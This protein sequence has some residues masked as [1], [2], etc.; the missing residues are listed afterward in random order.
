LILLGST[1]FGTA[2]GGGSSDYGTVFDILTNGTGFTTLASFSG[3]ND[4]A[5]PSAGLIYTLSGNALYGTAVY[6][7]TA[8]NG[9]V[10]TLPL[11]LAASTTAVSSSSNP[12]VY[13]QSGVT[14]TATVTSLMGTPT[15]TVQFLTNGQPFDSETLSGGTATSV[16]LPLTLSADNYTVTATYSGD[17]DFTTSSGSLSGGQ[18]VNQA[19]TLTVVGS[20]DAGTSVYGETGATFTATV[21]SATSGTPTGTVQFY[22]NTVAFG[23]AV[24][25]SGGTASSGALP[26]SLPGGNYGVT[27]I[28]SGDPN[29]ITSSGS[30]SGGQTV[31]KAASSMTLADSPDSNTSVYGQ[32][33]VTF[34]ATVSD[35]SSGSSGTPTGSVQFFTNSVAFGNPVALTGGPASIAISGSLSITLMP[36]NYTVTASYSGDQD[37]STCSGTLSGGQ[38]VS[39]ATSLTSVTSSD[40]G[41][42]LYGQSGVTFMATVSDSSTS[43]S[44]TPTGSVQFYTNTVPFGSAVTLS[45]GSASVPLPTHLA[46]GNYTVTAAYSGDGDFATSS[47]TLSGGQ[48]V[49]Q[50]TSSTMVVSSDATSAF[51]QSGVTFTATV[52]DTSTGSSGTPTGTVQ[53]Q[54][55]GQPFGLPVSLSGGSASSGSLSI[56]LAPGS[57]SVTAAYSGDGDF[58]T[59]SGTLSGGQTVSKAG[60]LTTVV[61]S[62]GGSSLYGQSGVTFTATV[63]DASSGSTGTPTGTV[64]FYTNAVAFGSAVTL[65]GGSASSGSLSII[66]VPGGYTVT[67]AYSGDGDFVTSSGT[68]SGGQTVSKAGSSTAVATALNPSVYGNAV[69]F[70]ATVTDTSS[71]SS[72]TPQGTVTFLTNGTAFGSASLSGGSASVLLPLTTPAGSYTV[73]ATYTSDGSLSGSTGTLSTGSGVQNVE[74]A[75]SATAVSSPIANPSVFG[76]SGV[77]F[78]AMVTDA[79]SA[80]TG[81]PT[82]TVQFY[83]NTIPFGTPV[84]LSGGSASSGALPITL[85]LMPFGNSWWEDC[86]S[87][88]FLR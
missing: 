58:A 79:S 42:S 27:A 73:T 67:A 77:T 44:G 43:S 2:N 34:T 69:T 83:T 63:S 51:G 86:E 24:T 85:A 52:S 78:T 5:Y 82:G 88:G 16:A 64:Q 47:G 62:D 28:Y 33:G 68:L 35:S 31:N 7:G 9:T 46:P 74:K 30:L 59:S 4:G 49:N 38:T 60:S 81:T 13:G 57:Y 11:A 10:F 18:T 1:L 65:S 45:G 41:S 20:S 70:T 25:L 3:G 54:T 12:S 84:S 87:D 8:G 72:A 40:A 56:T 36:G 29:F 15:G 17:G 80:S 21:T 22:T 19:G 48:T 53:F 55:N 6:G 50:A 76:Q 26:A 32:S 14:F 37:F 71:G 61:S 75:A 39:K 66:L 23:S